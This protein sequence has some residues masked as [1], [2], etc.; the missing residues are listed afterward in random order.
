VPDVFTVAKRSQ[1]MSLIRGRGNKTTELRFVVLLRENRI[2]GWRRHVKLPGR[3]DFIFFAAKLAV[4][5]DG[6]FWHG[7]PATYTSPQSNKVFWENKIAYN[8]ENDKR[9]TKS[10]KKRGWKVLRIWESDLRKKPKKILTRLKKG[11]GE[12][13]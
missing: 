6:D 8:R 11:L 3:P 12:F 4:F 1:V 9:V 10:L 13:T 7:N 5:I 2:T